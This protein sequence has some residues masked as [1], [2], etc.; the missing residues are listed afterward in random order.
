[1]KRTSTKNNYCVYMHENKLNGKK[2]IG[3]TYNIKERWRCKGKTILLVLNF[4]MHLK[5]M[6]GITLII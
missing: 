1:M 3:Q 2:Y 4:L 5:S 6:V